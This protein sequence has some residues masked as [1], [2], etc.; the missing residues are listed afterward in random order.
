VRENVVVKFIGRF[1]ASTIVL[2]CAFAYVLLMFYLVCV[3]S[4]I[5]VLLGLAVSCALIALPWTIVSMV[6][7]V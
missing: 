7:D 4:N 3:C 6:K 2:V 5:N 1:L